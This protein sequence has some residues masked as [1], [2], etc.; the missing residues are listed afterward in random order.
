LI[1]QLRGELRGHFRDTISALLASPA[2]FDAR[3]LQEA[4]HVCI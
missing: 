4:M 3:T 1:R 2:E